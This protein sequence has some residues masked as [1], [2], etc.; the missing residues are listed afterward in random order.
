MNS[1]TTSGNSEHRCRFCEQPTTVNTSQFENLLKD[2][3]ICKQF[4]E[5]FGF[6]V[7]AIPSY[8]LFYHSMKLNFIPAQRGTRTSISNL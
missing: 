3:R 8:T 4:N 5:Y 1:P 2:K 6:E 7:V